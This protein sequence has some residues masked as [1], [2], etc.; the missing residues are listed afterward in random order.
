MINFPWR[1]KTKD[2]TPTI[3]VPS[4]GWDWNKFH[5]KIIIFAASSV[6]GLILAFALA[7]TVVFANK[8]N[9]GNSKSS[10]NASFE[11]KQGETSMKLNLSCDNSNI[12]AK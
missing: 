3:S 11:Y 1:K 7:V 6:L 12:K 9:C 4:N 10:S 8:D 2:K 5:T